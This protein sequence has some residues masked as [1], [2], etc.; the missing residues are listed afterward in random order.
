M[1]DT[2]QLQRDIAHVL[3]C[4]GVDAKLGVADYALAEEVVNRLFLSSSPSIE[5]NDD[6]HTV[7][8]VESLT[9]LYKIPE[10]KIKFFFQDMVRGMEV[11]RP[12]VEVAELM[13]EITGE[14]S[15]SK[16]V[17]DLNKF[18]WI[19]DGKYGDDA[20]M[21]NCH[22]RIEANPLPGSTKDETTD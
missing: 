9:Q 17:I 19:D 13:G 7:Y 3:N 2:E 16:R 21:S 18:Q 6:G 14:S 22:V 11:M 8:T 5:V 15:G 12:V 1:T 10:D 4:H 20:D